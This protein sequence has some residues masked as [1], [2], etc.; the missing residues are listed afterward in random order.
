MAV[1]SKASEP[2]PVCPS[3]L[4]PCVFLICVNLRAFA[5]NNS[6]EARRGSQMLTW[7]FP[8]QSGNPSNRSL[9]IPA[10]LFILAYFFLFSYDGLNA[11]LTFDDGM[12]IIAMHHHWE[13]SI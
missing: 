10:S 3:L 5:A 2:R 13:V 8:M 11:H 12:N 4:A 6:E 9:F 1:L 7:A